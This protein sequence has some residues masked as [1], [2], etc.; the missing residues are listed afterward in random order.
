MQGSSLAT[1][2]VLATEQ[3]RVLTKAGKSVLRALRELC[4]RIARLAVARLVRLG[5]TRALQVSSHA[6]PVQRATEPIQV[7]RQAR[8]NASFVML[9]SFRPIVR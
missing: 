2:A 5:L 1:C 8:H 9:A 6:V 7:H 3:T 4:Q